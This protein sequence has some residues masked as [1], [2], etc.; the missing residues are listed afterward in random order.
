VGCCY[1]AGAFSLGSVLLGLLL[2]QWSNNEV[3]RSLVESVARQW[4]VSNNGVVFSLGSVL[5]A[6]CRRITVLSIQPELQKGY[7]VRSIHA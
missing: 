4:P 2:W 3:K 7:I 6:S 5:R 1:A